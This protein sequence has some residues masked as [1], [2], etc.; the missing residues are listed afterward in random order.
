MVF[1]KLNILI[2][3]LTSVILCSCAHNSP[4]IEVLDEKANYGADNVPP[5]ELMSQSGL[6]GSVPRRS[7]SKEKLC[8]YH[9]HELPSQDYFLGGWIKLVYEDAHWEPERSK[10]YVKKRSA[11]PKPPVAKKEVKKKSALDRAREARFD[12]PDFTDR[13]RR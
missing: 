7:G 2:V 13:F 4:K 11:K 1:T 5:L 3:C 8:W 6:H 9:P 10:R 12:R